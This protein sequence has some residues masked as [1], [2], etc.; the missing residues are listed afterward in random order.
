MGDLRWD[1]SAMVYANG[2]EKNHNSHKAILGVCLFTT[3]MYFITVNTQLHMF[4]K[5]HEQ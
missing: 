1:L 2:L 5:S 4:P 3:S